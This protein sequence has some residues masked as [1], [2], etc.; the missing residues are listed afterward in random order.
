[1]QKLHVLGLV[2]AYFVLL[3]ITVS[4]TGS[5]GVLLQEP[6]MKYSCR[7]IAYPSST[8]L[9][10]GTEIQGK[11]HRIAVG[12]TQGAARAVP[13]LTRPFVHGIFREYP[14]PR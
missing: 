1:M 7:K 9:Q 5:E 12:T 6:F 2:F 11:Y 8:L 14:V 3:Q 13:A 4:L 10:Q